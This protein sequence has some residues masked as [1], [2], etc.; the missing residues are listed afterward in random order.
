M[1]EIL[2]LARRDYLARDELSR[3]NRFRTEDNVSE[4]SSLRRLCDR[5]PLNVNKWIVNDEIRYRWLVSK[6]TFLGEFAGV[7]SRDN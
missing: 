5:T 7:L 3:D 1:P 6:C 4:E 2:S